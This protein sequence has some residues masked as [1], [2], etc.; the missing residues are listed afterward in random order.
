MAMV[1]QDPLGNFRFRVE[2]DGVAVAGFSEALV[3]SATTDVIEYREG[4]D[5]M[6]VRKLPG[7]SKFDNITLKRGLGIEFD[8]ALA[9][10]KALQARRPIDMGIIQSCKAWLDSLP[11]GTKLEPV[12]VT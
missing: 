1:R 4:T 8:R 12:A 7:L 3:G 9:E 2:I 10:Q 6:L 5:P 11:A